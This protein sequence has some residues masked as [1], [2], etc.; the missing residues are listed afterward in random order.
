MIADRGLLAEVHRIDLAVYEA[1]VG[2][3]PPEV[4]RAF[5]RLSNAANYSRLSIAAAAL[6]SVAGGPR[7]RRAAG[8][9]L[10]SV[11]VTSAVV[12]LVLKPLSGRRRPQRAPHRA[13]S[14]APIPM[15]ES[16]S[17]PSGHSAAAFAFAAGAGRELPA[18]GVPLGLL[19]TL[20]AY[21]RI[22][23][24]VHYPTDVV[25]GATCGVA[26][27]AAVNLVVDRRG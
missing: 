15:P 21:S 7:G 3:G 26:I 2:A 22:H 11:G 19:A 8:R 1:I 16:D 20:V 23:T 6:L 5:R 13:G 17:F 12:N 4:D 25:V 24:G 10:A 14:P 18:A 27:A 9:G